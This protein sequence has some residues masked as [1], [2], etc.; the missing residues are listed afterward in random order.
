[1]ETTEMAEIMEV[2]GVTAINYPGEIQ[3]TQLIY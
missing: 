2:T 1:M 3:A